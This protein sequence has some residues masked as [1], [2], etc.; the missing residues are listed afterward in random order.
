MFSCLQHL[1]CQTPGGGWYICDEV[2]GPGEMWCM[3]GCVTMAGHGA[4]VTCLRM[5]QWLTLCVRCFAHKHSVWHQTTIINLRGK[6]KQH[7]MLT[8]PCKQTSLELE[9]PLLHVTHLRP[10]LQQMSLLIHCSLFGGSC[11]AA[12]SGRVS[13]HCSTAVSSHTTL[14]CLQPRTS[15]HWLT[16]QCPAPAARPRLL[17]QRTAHA[18][19]RLL[20]GQQSER[21]PDTATAT[22]YHEKSHQ[23]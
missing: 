2:W 12:L 15:G 10:V 6:Y 17:S 19:M 22:H 8:A 5:T 13:C 18:Q 1:A 23:R 16:A 9:R 21:T 11:P 14:Q 20:S 4:H 3:M 7:Y